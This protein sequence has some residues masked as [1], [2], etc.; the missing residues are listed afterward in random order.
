M[1]GTIE[2]I[3]A[4][5]ARQDATPVFVHTGGAWGLMARRDLF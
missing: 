3:R 2:T 5:K 1:T 4:G